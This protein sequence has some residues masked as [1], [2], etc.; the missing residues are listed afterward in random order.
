MMKILKTLLLSSIFVLVMC[1]TGYAQDEINLTLRCDI[2][3]LQDGTAAYQ[4]CR[5]VGQ[6]PDTDTRDHTVYANVGDTIFWSGESTDGSGAID[7]QKIKYERGTNVFDRDELDGTTTVTGII[8]RNTSNK[9]DYK[10]TISFKIDGTGK[11]YSID[12][13]LKVGD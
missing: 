11:M 10:Y 9:P 13:K 4:A 2:Q 5:F 12:P 6:D 3:A 8:K 1:N 7:I